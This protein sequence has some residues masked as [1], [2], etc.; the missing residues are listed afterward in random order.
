[1]EEEYGEPIGHMIDGE[2]HRTDGKCDRCEMLVQL[3]SDM[4]RNKELKDD[5]KGIGP[6]AIS[7]WADKMMKK[8]YGYVPK[9]NTK[10]ESI[11]HITINL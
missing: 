7:A 11:K 4:E 2:M 5:I 8:L 3:I 1:M 9:S 6:F 10:N